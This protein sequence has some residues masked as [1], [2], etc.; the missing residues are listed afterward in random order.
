MKFSYSGML[1]RKDSL[2]VDNILFEGLGTS[3]ELCGVVELL[4]MGHPEGKATVWQLLLYWVLIYIIALAS[5]FVNKIHSNRVMKWH[6]KHFRLRRPAPNK[7]HQFS[8][9][10]CCSVI[11]K[12]HP[13]S[14][15]LYNH[16]NL[17]LHLFLCLAEEVSHH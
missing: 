13:M 3:G 4:F 11:L 9:H 12:C 5:M 7:Y 2:L 16:S 15:K 6:F 8:Y 1:M 10:L 14:P 17:R